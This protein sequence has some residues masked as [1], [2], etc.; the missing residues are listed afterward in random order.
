MSLKWASAMWVIPTTLSELSDARYCSKM[1][2]IGLT[3]WATVYGVIVAALFGGG[4][5]VVGIVGL[6]QARRAKVAAGK[7]NDLAAA[8]N[9]IAVGANKLASEANH[10]SKD[11]NNLIAAQD[12][13]LTERSDVEW[14]WRWDSVNPDHVIIQNIGKSLAKKVVAQFWAGD[15]VKA[16][17][18]SP[19]DVDGQKSLTLRIPELAEMRRLAAQLSEADRLSESPPVVRA[20]RTR[21]RVAWETPLGTFGHYSSGYQESELINPADDLEYLV[22]WEGPTKDDTDEG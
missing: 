8:A 13:R 19:V 10:I 22:W 15:F 16:N 6:V 17:D 4:G 5:L 11:A 2:D 3:A 14:E 7:A 18:S 12:A 21:L 1:N 9:S 20:T